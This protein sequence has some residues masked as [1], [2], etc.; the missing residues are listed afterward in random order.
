MIKLED[1]LRIKQDIDHTPVDCAYCGTTLILK[2]AHTH[3]AGVTRFPNGAIMP[4][5]GYHC[6]RCCYLAKEDE[7]DRYDA[8][9]I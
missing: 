5:I 3:S 9:E 8:E 1:L 4:E 2:N 7:E 6:A